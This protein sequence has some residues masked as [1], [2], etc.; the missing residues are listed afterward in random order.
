MAPP[1]VLQLPQNISRTSRRMYCSPN[2]SRTFHAKILMHSQKKQQR[3]CRSSVSKPEKRRP[4]Q[5]RMP[6]TL[7]DSINE[8]CPSLFC[9]RYWYLSDQSILIRD[10]L[11]LILQPNFPITQRKILLQSMANET[12]AQFEV[13]QRS[14]CNTCSRARDAS[15]TPVMTRSATVVSTKVLPAGKEA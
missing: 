8:C 11:N 2:T 1:P 15:I 10:T 14:N 5:S 7:I 13:Q 3:R 9:Q 12:L 4:T 6:P